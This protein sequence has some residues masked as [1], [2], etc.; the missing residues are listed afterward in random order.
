MT[1]LQH[2]IFLAPCRPGVSWSEAQ[3][4]WRSH[5]ETIMLEIPGLIGYVQDRP[6]PEWW[7]HLPYLA[8]SETWF[9]D[10]ESERAAYASHWYTSQI[11]VDEA[12]MLAR[13]DAWS[14]P[15]TAVETLRPGRTGRF[16]VLAFGASASPLDSLLIDARAEL[17]RL[18][19]PP[20]N[21]GEATVVSVWTDDA[22]LARHV[23]QRLGG[24][25]FVAEPAVS[26][27]PP[28]PPWGAP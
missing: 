10:R 17:L 15:V 28:Q 22:G 14:S 1:A 13:D 27:A 9:A 24:L 8:C 4:H 3:A 18:H 16:R 26:L 21:G 23:A 7:V 12:R 6:C 2:R 19:R 20:P 11:A 5:H 25:T